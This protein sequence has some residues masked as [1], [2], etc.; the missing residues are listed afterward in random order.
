MTESILDKAIRQYDEKLQNTPSE[1][2]E[3]VCY[4]S[5]MVVWLE[6]LRDLREFKARVMQAVN[7][8]KLD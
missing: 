5:Q 8:Y 6:E 4:Y 1:N 3:A 7:K 2:E